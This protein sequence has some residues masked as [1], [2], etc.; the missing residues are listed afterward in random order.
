MMYS[1]TEYEFTLPTGREESVEAEDPS[2]AIDKAQRCLGGVSEVNYERR[3]IVC[4]HMTYVVT[5]AM[6]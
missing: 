4:D 1:I 2:E 6:A 5:P 3:T